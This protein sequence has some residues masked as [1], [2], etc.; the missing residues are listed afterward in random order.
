[1]QVQAVDVAACSSSGRIDLL[2]QL[3]GFQVFGVLEGVRPVSPE[4]RHLR[5][6]PVPVEIGVH[7]AVSP[8]HGGEV[9]DE[10]DDFAPHR[11]PLGLEACEDSLQRPQAGRL[12]AV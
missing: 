10:A 8:R 4:G 2:E 7:E 12:V 5:R 6:R 3:S 9:S 1:M 11:R